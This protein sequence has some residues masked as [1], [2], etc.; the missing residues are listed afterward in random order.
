MIETEYLSSFEIRGALVD[1]SKYGAEK[2]RQN[3]SAGT[4][5]DISSDGDIYAIPDDGGPVALMYRKDIFDKYHLTVPTT[6]AQFEADAVKLKA[7]GGPAMADFPSDTPQFQQSLA[8]QAGSKAFEYNQ[9]NRTSIGIDTDNAAWQKVMTFW[10]GMISKNLV[11]TT[12]EQTTDYT[13]GLGDGKYA[14]MIAPSWEPGHLTG[15]GFAPGKGSPWRVAPLPQWA[16]GDNAQ[17]NWGGSTY[18]VTTQSKHPKLAAEVAIYL[19]NDETPTTIGAH[20]PQ[21]VPTQKRSWFAPAKDPFFAYQQAN[22]EVWIPASAGY[23]GT[24]YSPFQQF[25][26][27]QVNTAAIA[28]AAGKPVDAALQK[29]QSTTVSYAQSQGF[30]VKK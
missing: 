19:F 21:H 6:W 16:A 5:K 23:K 29:L 24:V 9:S 2:V 10:Q 17:V 12:G 20:F 18:T 3:F 25:Y 22:K 7:E 27:A 8:N 15:N 11:A 28:I 4:L 13:A 26:Y 14:T 1:L 30:Q